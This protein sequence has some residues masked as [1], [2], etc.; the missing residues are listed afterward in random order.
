MGFTMEIAGV[1]FRVESEYE[2]LPH[3]CREYLCEVPVQETVTV[4]EADLLAEQA[5][6]RDSDAQLGLDRSFSDSVYISNALFRKVAEALPRHGAFPVHGS[7]VAVDGKAYLFMADS[8]TGKSTHT[9]LWREYFGERADMVNDDKPALLLENGVFY[10]CGTPW[11]GKHHLGRNC[12][13]PL[14]GICMLV[15]GEENRI[16]RIT[17]E[18]ALAVVYRYCYHP[19]SKE[20]LLGVVSLL[21][22]LTKQVP[23]YRGYFNMELTAPEVSFRGM[24][25]NI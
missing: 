9:R 16:E 14:T 5:Q 25:G 24:G 12:K 6:F 2:L 17:P 13:V 22:A 8:G 3:L 20:G 1:G 15:R 19:F 10:A 7:C 18:D 4:T 11:R 21:P 23:V